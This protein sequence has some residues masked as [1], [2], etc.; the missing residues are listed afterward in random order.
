MLAS[1]ELGR[2]GLELRE[3]TRASQLSPV[4]FRL[5][6]PLYGLCWLQ[7]GQTA[8]MS[9]AYWGQTGAMDLLIKNG[10]E[11]EARNEVP[12]LSH[13]VCARYACRYLVRHSFDG[14]VELF[15]SERHGVRQGRPCC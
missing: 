9:A 8:L 15:V 14:M 13:P 7:N 4:Q 5:L 2:S 10:A 6:L 11:I 1:D 3:P 12:S